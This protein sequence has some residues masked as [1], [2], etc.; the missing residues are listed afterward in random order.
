MDQTS[1]SALKGRNKRPAMFPH[2]PRRN[3]FP[4]APRCFATAP[5]SFPNRAAIVSPFQGYPLDTSPQPRASATRCLRV[6]FALG[7][8]IAPF[9]G[10]P[11]DAPRFDLVALVAPEVIEHFQG[12]SI[13]RSAL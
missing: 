4:T 12:G 6:A 9:Q 11:L 1:A 2:Q 13:G 3:R 7:W 5:Q 10:G 8:F